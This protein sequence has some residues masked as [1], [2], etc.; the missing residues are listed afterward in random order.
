MQEE[1][2]FLSASMTLNWS[3]CAT[4]YIDS[5]ARLSYGAEKLGGQGG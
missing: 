1:Y 4:Q 2:Q 5:G 3:Y